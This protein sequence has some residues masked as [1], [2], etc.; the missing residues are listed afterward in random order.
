M[1]MSPEVTSSRPAMSL[2]SVDL[3]QPDGPTKTTNSPSAISRLASRIT[4]TT[5]KVFESASIVRRAMAMGVQVS[6]DAGRGDAG[7]DVALQEDESQ[8]EWQRRQGRH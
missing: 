7:G 8:R 6:F 4:S 3:P 5:P 1:R 2:N